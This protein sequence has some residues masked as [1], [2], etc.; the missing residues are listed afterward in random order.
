MRLVDMDRFECLSGF[1]FSSRRRHTRFD[2]DWSSDVC[3]S[4]LVALP[5]GR[6]YVPHGRLCA[7]GRQADL[8]GA[9][10]TA[11]PP[12]RGRARPGVGGARA[13][14]HGARAL[15]YSAGARDHPGRHGDPP[16]AGADRGVLTPMPGPD[17]VRAFILEIGLGALLLLVFVATLGIRG[18]ERR[19]IGWTATWGGLGPAFTD[20]LV[21][22][23]PPA[24]GG[25]LRRDGPP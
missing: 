21:R 25:M 8:L 13:P 4:D 24:P 2:C 12:P 11:L 1:F 14:R 18:A 22:P 20:F 16:L 15:R 5:R 19:V 3:S 7:A 17:A 23:R 10:L 6:G 9:A